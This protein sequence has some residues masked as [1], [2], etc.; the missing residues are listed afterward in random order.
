[1]T[2]VLYDT[3]GPRTITRNRVAGIISTVGIV[4]LLAWVGYRFY[5][6]GQFDAIRW[7]Q[8]EYKAVQDA[9]LSG[10]LNTLKAAGIAAVG[11]VAFG[12]IFA[13]ARLSELWIFRRPATFIVELFRAVPLLILIIFAFYMPLQYHLPVDQ[14]WAVVI[15][16][17]LYNGSVLAEIFRAGME[18][19]PRGQS[20]A[21]YALGLRKTQV[22]VS[23]LLPQAVRAMLPAIVSQLV[24]LLK[25][26]ALGFIINF[27]ELLYAGKQ[28]GG[29]LSFGFP[30]VPAYL[31]VA[32][33]YIG[34]C[35]LLSFIASRPQKRMGSGRKRKTAAAPLPLANDPGGI[36]SAGAI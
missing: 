34:I 5:A 22:N 23:V 1:M 14:L 29:R 9:L 13:T 31:V 16:L 21:G 20:E 28:I 18:A 15:G 35:G 32:V 24:V 33:V 17:V 25:D 30:F 7:E 8:F 11:A 3:P 26:T 4:A 6:T 12:A 10:L 19:V 27:H 2:T 36:G